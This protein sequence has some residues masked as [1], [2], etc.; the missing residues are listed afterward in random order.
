MCPVTIMD[1]GIIL[2]FRTPDEIRGTPAENFKKI[3]IS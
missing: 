3:F 2:Q 1:K